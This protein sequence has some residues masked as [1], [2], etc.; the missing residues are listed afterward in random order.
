VTQFVLIVLSHAMN[1]T[2]RALRVA[3]GKSIGWTWFHILRFRRGVVLENLRLAY[4]KE[5]TEAE[6]QK[7]AAANFH[8]YGLLI[9]EIIQSVTWKSA[10]YARNIPFDG[11]ENLKGALAKGQ[12]AFVLSLHIG[13]WEWT[14]GAL[15]A[16]GIA[17]DAVVKRSKNA[18]ADKF[19]LDHRQNMGMGILF[20][21]G[22]AKDILRSL[23]KG[24]MVGFML[25]QFMGPPIGLPVNFFGKLAGTAIGLALISE[26]RKAPL[27]LVYS[28]RDEN[29]ILRA[30]AEPELQLPALPEDREDRMYDKTQFYNDVLEKCVR[31]HPD[32]WLWLHRRWKSYRGEPRWKRN[33]GL[34]PAT[35]ALLL[36]LLTGCATAYKTEETPTGIALPADAVVNLPDAL[37]IE[38]KAAEPTPAPEAPK[39][40]KTKKTKAATL[41]VPVV[42]SPKSSFNPRVFT[43]EQVPFEVGERM[44]ISLN[45]TALPAGDV[46]LEVREGLGFQGRNTFKIWGNV[47]SSPVVDAIY[48]VDN[49]IESYID[50]EW[51]LP[52]KFILHMVETHQLKET[53]AVFD[54]KLNQV[55]YWSKRISKKWGDDVQDRVDNS[56]PMARDMFSALYYARVLEYK[57]GEAREI[58]IYENR[59]NIVA[60]LLPVAN[61][62]VQTKA[63]AFQCWK[64]AVTVKIDNVLKPS[65]DMFLW[66]S[67]DWKKYIVKFDAKLKIG[68]L[69]GELTSLRERL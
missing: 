56:L 53:K 30:V 31:Q 35:V 60:S 1:R 12:G 13:N 54:H 20:E 55:H 15:V 23:G 11:L 8:H 51:L 50:K 4:G 10:D 5:K 46:R 33:P 57:M 36:A 3:L 61:E 18:A 69:R 64:M 21:S 52:Y 22:T 32:Q 37:A 6:L 27:V 49:T 24:R 39:A 67:D 68:S 48:H 42:A 16:N 59:Q 14:M 43:P 25:D 66:F 65:G 44:V 26:K 58:P 28:Y 17:A 62:M 2:P 45:W 63:G 34:V 29:G 19:L 7:I 41:P 40:K 38:G 9:T 47:L